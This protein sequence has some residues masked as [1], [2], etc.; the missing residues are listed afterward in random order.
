[1]GGNLPTYGD[2]PEDEDNQVGIPAEIELQVSKLAAQA[3]QKLLQ[4]HIQEQQA[5]QNQQKQQDPLIQMQQQELQIKAQDLQRKAKRDTDDIAV[6]YAKLGITKSKNDSVAEAAGANVAANLHINQS[7]LRE[8][9]LTSA[10][11]IGTDI[12]KTAAQHE[13][14][15][16]MAAKQ[17]EVKKL[18]GDKKPTGNKK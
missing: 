15:K 12:A 10:A 3:S 17:A 6:E 11:K 9:H 1:M 18:T 8:Q 14:D 13:H 5:Q 4:S 16:Q 2:S 7:K